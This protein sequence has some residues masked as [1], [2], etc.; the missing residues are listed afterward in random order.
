M[1]TPERPVILQNHVLTNVIITAHKSQIQ[2]I[3]L[4][5]AFVN[6]IQNR[7]TLELIVLQKN[8]A[9]R[10]IE[11]CKNVKMVEL[12]VVIQWTTIAFAIAMKQFMKV[13]LVQS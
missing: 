6:V 5:D 3:L 12:L 7:I 2:T 1:D 11:R 10:R 8:L 9:M 13:L 4:Q